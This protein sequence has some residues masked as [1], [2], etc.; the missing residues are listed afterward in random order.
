LLSRWPTDI[1]V[2]V[3]AATVLSSRARP[4]ALAEVVSLYERLRD[5]SE[6]AVERFAS[7]R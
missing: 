6:H 5:V 7:R 1:E 4:M 3:H 2:S